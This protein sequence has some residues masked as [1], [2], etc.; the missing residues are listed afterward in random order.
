MSHTSNVEAG[1]SFLDVRPCHC[2]GGIRLD[3][4]SLSESHKKAF[5]LL[6]GAIDDQL[7]VS[8]SLEGSSLIGHECRA[9]E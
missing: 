5:E 6:V 3:S 1:C 4:S 8:A 7:R 9:I 2:K